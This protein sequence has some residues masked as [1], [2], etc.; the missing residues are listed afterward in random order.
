MKRVSYIIILSALIS[1]PVLADF[2]NGPGYTGGKA[3]YTRMSGYYTGGGGEFTL[4]DTR[5]PS[6]LLSNSA[7]DS[8][9]RGL[10]SSHPESFQTFCLEADEYAA[11]PM[12]IW[13]SEASVN[14]S[15]GIAGIYGSGSHAW[16]GGTNTNNGDNLD[17]FTAWLYTQFATGNLAEYAY[18]GKNIYDLNRS[19][20]AGALQWLIWD[21]EDETGG[22]VNSI[23]PTGN[24]VNLINDW[25]NLYNV[26]GWTGLGDV[27]VLQNSNRRGGAAQDFLYLV[28]LPGA[29]IL[30]MLSLGGVSIAG[31]KL[32]KF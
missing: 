3:R 21:T 10:L 24:Q 14:E 26:S 6:L 32:R 15:N 4:Y 5:R 17:P 30:C 22:P 27:R 12:K 31:W 13:V 1:S 28:P 7:Y 9:T 2:I 16:G 20:T 18:I 8:K 29:I 23:A 19:Q 11:R 25:N